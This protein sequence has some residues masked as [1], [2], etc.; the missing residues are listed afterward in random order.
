M[1]CQ[2]FPKDGI[3][4]NKIDLVLHKFS[5]ALDSLIPTGIWVTRI[6]LALRIYSSVI[7]NVE[8]KCNF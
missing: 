8:N 1:L 5:I 3:K 4:E 7:F 6:F 2:F